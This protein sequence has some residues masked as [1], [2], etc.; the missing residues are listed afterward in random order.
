MSAH[1]IK[2]G[3]DSRPRRSFHFWSV[4]IKIGRSPFDRITLFPIYCWQELYCSL[5]NCA[6]CFMGIRISL[7]FYRLFSGSCWVALGLFD[8]FHRPLFHMWP[9]NDFKTYFNINIL[10]CMSS[11]FVAFFDANDSSPVSSDI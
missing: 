8:C 10:V 3:R 2:F 5:L 11:L 7:G 1:S 6:V 9:H 4:A